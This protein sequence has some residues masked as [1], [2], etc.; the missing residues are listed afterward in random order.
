M[1]D[2]IRPSDLPYAGST[3]KGVGFCKNSNGDILWDSGGSISALG[4]GSGVAQFAS[5]RKTVALLGDSY[6]VRDTPTVASGFLGT[7]QKSIFEWANICLNKRLKPLYNG[8]NNAEGLTSYDGI[9]GTTVTSF[10]TRIDAIIAKGADYVWIPGSVNNSDPTNYVPYADRVSGY[11]TLIQKV[12]AAGQIPIV[13]TEPPN[14]NLV[15]ASGGYTALTRQTDWF[16]FNTWLR[17]EGRNMGAIVADYQNAGIDDPVSLVGGVLSSYI[18]AGVHLTW[19]AAQLVGKAFAASLASQIP[20]WDIPWQTNYNASATGQR[21]IAIPN[22][23]MIDSNADGFADR[24]GAGGTGVVASIE[25][26]TDGVQG[27]WQKLVWTPAAVGGSMY[28]PSS[29][30]AFNL[31]DKSIGDTIELFWEVQ[32]DDLNSNMI[33]GCLININFTGAA[34]VTSRS[35]QFT[36]YAGA[37]VGMAKGFIGVMS[38]AEIIIPAGTTSFSIQNNW[39]AAATGLPC[40]VRMGR[41]CIA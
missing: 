15:S 5:P 39:Y 19:P 38:T 18:D 24:F 25:R 34:G 32:V 10:L 2:R 31:G 40:T 29:G 7:S 8:Y 13:T 30:G 3:P 17:T 33:A 23:I 16:K 26:R 21:I 20:D 41:V 4:G 1:S 35:Y 22:P 14:A 28:M 12:L 6:V 9:S 37:G 36:D 27:N 11:T